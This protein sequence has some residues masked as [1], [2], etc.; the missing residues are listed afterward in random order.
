[1]SETLFLKLLPVVY[2]LLIP[3]GYGVIRLFRSVATIKFYLRK[4]CVE[5]KID[6]G[7]DID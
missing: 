2:L 5:M 7:K 4:I 3:A 1:M 6:C